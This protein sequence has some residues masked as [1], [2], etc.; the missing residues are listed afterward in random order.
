MLKVGETF[1]RRDSLAKIIER[2]GMLV[3]R[4]QSLWNGIHFKCL[5]FDE[6]NLECACSFSVYFGKSRKKSDKIKEH[7]E[8]G[9]EID[10]SVW[11]IP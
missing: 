9:Q 4:M 1:Q 3:G 7:D 8:N 6:E 10:N 2:H 5:S 11:F